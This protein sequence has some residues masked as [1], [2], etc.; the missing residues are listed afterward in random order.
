[1]MAEDRLVRK[2]S[3]VAVVVAPIVLLVTALV[4]VALTIPGD[5]VADKVLGQPD[6]SDNVPNRVRQADCLPWEARPAATL[7][8]FDPSS[9][10]PV[11]ASD[12]GNNRVLGWRDATAFSNGAPADLVIGQPDFSGYWQNNGGISASSL[13]GPSGV[14]VDSHGNLY[15]GDTWNF[16][17]L[18]YT[19]PFA[20]CAGHFP[21]VGWSSGRGVRTMRQLHGQQSFGVYEFGHQ[22][23]Y[24]R[25]LLSCVPLPLFVDATDNLWVA[26]SGNNRVLEFFRPI[27][28]TGGT[29]G[30]PGAAGDT[31]ADK[32]F[33]QNG[34]FSGFLCNENKVTPTADTL[35]QPVDM[36]VDKDNNVWIT[37][38]ANER[39]LEYDNPFAKGG[40]TPG[41]P[42]SAGDTTADLVFGQGGNFDSGSNPACFHS[43]SPDTLCFPSGIIV[44]PDVN[45]FIAESGTAR[46][47]EY[48]DP[49][50][51]GGGTPGTPGSKGDTTADMVFGQG[52][53]SGGTYQNFTSNV[54]YGNEG[55][56]GGTPGSPI[57]NRPNSDGLCSP[58][59][60]GAR[61]RR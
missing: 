18:E 21:C 23:R 44:D 10:R 56:V 38:Y 17:V 25:Q 24:A 48:D 42:G 40:G 59:R 3:I 52:G 26:D 12:G 47:L 37:D 6:F 33:G 39:A 50:V 41:K 35:C 34:S 30:K 20:A 4:A 60:L 22:C 9:N 57:T 61:Y 8:H 1:M 27:P 45:V 53:Y 11:Y 5:F 15:V 36:A 16:R 28:L 51:P 7:W 43:E 14:A 58:E 55:Q 31:T 32:V 13:D 54:C 2:I 29:P 19:D 49:L 46:V